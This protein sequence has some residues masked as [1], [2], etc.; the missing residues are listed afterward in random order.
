MGWGDSFKQALSEASESAKAAAQ[1]ALS[2]ARAAAEAVQQQAQAAAQQAAQALAAAKDQA[3]AG[4]KSLA[5]GAA[6]VARFGARA[7]GEV[8]AGAAAG[9]ANALTAPY[10]AARQMFSPS[11]PAVQTA[12]AKCP[13]T[14]AAKIERLEQ[15]NELIKA[16]RNDP[17][18]RPAAERL[19]Q[20]NQAVELARLSDNA[21]A[22][23][24][25]SPFQ[26]PDG[27][28][29][30]PPG[31]SVVP[32][33]ELEAR[34]VSVK[35][36]EDA[37]AV[38]Y[39][40]PDDWP[41]GAQTVVSFRG[42][43]DL[44]DAVVDHDQAMGLPTAQYGAAMRVGDSMAN[45]YGPGTQVTG[46]SLGGGKAQAAGMA[47]GLGGSM[48]N[49]AG[50]HPDTADAYDS[51]PAFT[52]FRTTGDPLTG[53]QNSPATQV[54]VGALAG[55][56]ATPLGAAAKLGDALS[57]FLGGPALPAELADYA[58]KAF[59]SFPRALQNVARH[60][61]MMPP[62]I[63]PI[64]EVPAINDAGETISGLNPMGQH[65]ITSVVNGIEQQKTEDMAAL[66]A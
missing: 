2:S 55:V 32:A 40:T 64:H 15:R 38:V 4:A 31:W 19:A 6:N 61:D 60:G 10:R 43:A 52:Q 17:A 49:A 53:V 16:G 34:G 42:T 57:Q 37:R 33:A 39:R 14:A 12:V 28:I 36:L 13:Q 46:H 51:S 50:L 35:D 27:T 25:K 8:V 30:A 54:A 41:G 47:G 22:Q 45:A 5:S 63:G 44:E 20:N 7:V 26:Y 29:P 65:S 9:A 23:Y 56:I 58:D 1:N 18:L 24:P 3:L 62:A 48:F 66:S 59:K 21:Y 11:R